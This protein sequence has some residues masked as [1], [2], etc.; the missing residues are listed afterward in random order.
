MIIR[1]SNLLCVHCAK[2]S[3]DLLASLTALILL[4]PV[5]LVVA[6]AIKLDS[7]GPVFYRQTRVGKS[8]PDKMVLFDIIKFR[9]MYQDAEQRSGAVW[10]SE[11][12]PRITSSGRFLRKTRLDEIPQLLNVLGG[13]MS[14]IGPRP[15]RPCF[16]GKLEHSIPYFTDRTY[17]VMPG[18]TGL[19]QIN[20]GY[21]TCIDD[22]RRKVGYDHSYALSLTSLK[23]WLA[24]DGMIIAQT[25]KVMF[26]GRGR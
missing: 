1:K 12:D 11:N 19:A 15:E 14:L 24:M 7:P 16:Y 6:A 10:A 3:F 23:S 9:T 4:M 20:Q 2:R 21:D 22:V 25:L 17:G 5:M 8:M 13:K 18:I 26:D